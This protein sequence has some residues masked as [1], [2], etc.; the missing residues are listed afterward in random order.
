MRVSVPQTPL[1]TAQAKTL[2]PPLGIELTHGVFEFAPSF[3]SGFARASRIGSA[4][5][6]LERIARTL[7]RPYR[8]LIRDASFIIRLAP[9]LLAFYLLLWELGSE[10]HSA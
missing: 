7:E 9:E 1:P 3:I 4:E 5:E 8:S 2:P 10:R 6:Y